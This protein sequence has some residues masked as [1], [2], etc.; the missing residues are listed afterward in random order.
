MLP[1][2]IILGGR[3]R[4]LPPLNLKIVTFGVFEVFFLHILLPP[5]K[6]V[7]ILPPPLERT[8]MSSLMLITPSRGSP[9]AIFKYGR[10]FWQLRTNFYDTI[11]LWIVIF[12]M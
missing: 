7:K 12:I 5:R 11:P 1:R 2:D 10:Y 6:S 4:H 3:G 8:E 9:H